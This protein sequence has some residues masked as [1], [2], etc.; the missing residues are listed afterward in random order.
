MAGERIND[1]ADGGQGQG[2]NDGHRLGHAIERSLAG[3][4]NVGATDNVDDSSFGD[5]APF[6]TFI[7]YRHLVSR[8]E[9]YQYLC[10]G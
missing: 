5:L 4:V 3:K 2:K 8:G 9:L 10:F 6:R 7:E 1:V